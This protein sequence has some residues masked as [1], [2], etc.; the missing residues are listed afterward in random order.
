[1][2]KHFSPEFL[3]AV[4][5]Q[6]KKIDLFKAIQAAGEEVIDVINAVKAGANLNE[7]YDD[8]LPLQCAISNNKFE[9]FKTLSALQPVIGECANLN[10]TIIVGPLK[11]DMTL[12]HYACTP[13]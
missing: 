4:K 9:R 1:M 8:M 12:L 2:K 11:T 6:D 3:I 5:A 7:P 10:A 13:I